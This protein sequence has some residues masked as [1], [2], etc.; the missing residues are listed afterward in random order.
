M[1]CSFLYTEKN[2]VS[3]LTLSSTLAPYEKMIFP[4]RTHH[5]SPSSHRLL[6][7]LL[8]AVGLGDGP[9][10][11]FA[12]N[13]L[14]ASARA[15]EREMAVRAGNGGAGARVAMVSVVSSS[16]WAA[17]TKLNLIE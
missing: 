15:I 6:P 7:P 1:S 2:Y 9:T 8:H 13:R 4:L 5:H 14:V 17:E 12:R 16:I 11:Y 3:Y 10:G